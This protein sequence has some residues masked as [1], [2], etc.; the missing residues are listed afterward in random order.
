MASKAPV[1]PELTATSR[2]A[3][4]WLALGC[5]ACWA[6]AGLA[7]MNS[8]TE[9]AARRE[10]LRIIEV[11]PIVIALR[12]ELTEFDKP[13]ARCEDRPGGKAHEETVL[14]DAGNVVQ[15]R[16]KHVRL[17]DT[18]EMR[19]E[20]EMAP[21]RDVGRTVGSMPQMEFAAHAQAVQQPGNGPLG[22]REAEGHDLDRERKAAELRDMLGSVGN[23]D[24]PLARGGDDL[25]AQESA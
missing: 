15:R 10:A 12:S 21:V 18:P 25:L 7:S 19:I 1:I 16:G 8:A 13:V 20:N 23:Y 11:A 4:R 5:C 9:V 6:K 14:H 17:V 2:P 3:A 22:G 24:H